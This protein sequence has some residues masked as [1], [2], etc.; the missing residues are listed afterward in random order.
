ML[1]DSLN[2]FLRKVNGFEVVTKLGFAQIANAPQGLV[3]TAFNSNI[4]T[5]LKAFKQSFTKEGKEFA[6]RSGAVLNSTLDEFARI[7]AEGGVKDSMATK[8]LRTTG[9]TALE[10]QNRILAALGGKMRAEW[11]FDIVQKGGKNK[12][13][14]DKARR[15]LDDLNVTPDE[16]DAALKRGALSQDELLQSGLSFSNT[17]QFRSDVLSLPEFFRSGW[18]KTFSQFKSFAFNHSR[19]LKNVVKDDIKD[20][21]RGDIKALANLLSKIGFAAA[22]G[23][24]P[25][26]LRMLLKGQSVSEREVSLNRLVENFGTIGGLGIFGDIHNSLQFGQSGV[27]GF[28]TGPAVS[29]AVRA[30][31]NILGPL[32]NGDIKKA[33]VGLLTEP[34]RTIPGFGTAI[35]K[36]VK[37]SFK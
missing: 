19:F 20:A 33:A 35:S 11:A 26:D 1:D 25:R 4:K 14:I 29:D 2:Q 32:A 21:A 34:L 22:I 8:F 6:R 30:S 24:V 18:G 3:N 7:G 36:K 27:F 10:T 12:R 15:V 37:E 31:V 13:L 17:T 9:F 16:L 28:V 23:E 5:A